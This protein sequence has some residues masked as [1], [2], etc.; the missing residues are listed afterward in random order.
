[1][2]EH[3]RSGRADPRDLPAA[4]NDPPHTRQ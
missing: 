4:A 3:P 2:V 1:V